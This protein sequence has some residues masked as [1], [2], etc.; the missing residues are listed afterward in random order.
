MSEQLLLPVLPMRDAVLF[1]GIAMPIGAGRAGTLRA[2]RLTR[3]GVWCCWSALMVK[4]VAATPHV[5]DFVALVGRE[6][7]RRGTRS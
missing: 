2:V 1:P 4:D 7:G 3:K 5:R 6:I